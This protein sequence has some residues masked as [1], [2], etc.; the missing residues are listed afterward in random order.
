MKRKQQVNQNNNY[1]TRKQSNLIGGLN[2]N[3]EHCVT[4]TYMYLGLMGVKI[5]VTLDKVQMMVSAL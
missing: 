3:F 5:V 2:V 4:L 1:L